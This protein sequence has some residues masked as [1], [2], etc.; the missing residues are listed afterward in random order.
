MISGD[1]T[2]MRAL[3]RLALAATLLVAGVCAAQSTAAQ[4]NY[5]SKPVRMVVPYPPAGPTDVIVRVISQRLAE[6]LGQSVVV[7]NRPGAS[8][9]IGAEQVARA[10]PDGYT[11]LVNPSIHVILPN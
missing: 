11:L 7:E 9:M 2:M 1:Q 4:S 10:A 8:G 3:F 5:P 6:E